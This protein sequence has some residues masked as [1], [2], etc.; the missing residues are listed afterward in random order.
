MLEKS[1]ESPLDSKEIKPVNP[2]GNQLW[3]QSCST[4]LSVYTIVKKLMLS[5]TQ[6][7]PC[8]CSSVAKSCPTL[9]NPM[10]QAPLSM[11]F[12][13]QEYWN[14][15]PGPPAGDLPDSGIEPVSPALQADPLTSEPSG[16]T[17]ESL[18]HK[19]K[20][21]HISVHTCIHRNF[22][23]HRPM[24]QGRDQVTCILNNPHST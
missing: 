12:S 7:S 8:C 15:L 20:D 11:G 9:C 18:S 10:V 22:C 4:T 21:D 16:K 14:A 1:L 17:F 19:K 3:T 2:K 24:I 6:F 5:L 13:R 23:R